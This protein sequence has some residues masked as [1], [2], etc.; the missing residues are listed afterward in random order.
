MNLHFS[1][2]VHLLILLAV[3]AVAGALVM[4]LRRRSEWGRSVRLALGLILAASELAWYGY[5]L[6]AGAFR[7]PDGLPLQLCDLTLW[8]AVAAALTLRPGI[9]EIAYYW[10]LGGDSMALLTPD[11]WAPFPSYPT[12]YFFVSHGLVVITVLTLT[13]GRLI[14]P[15]PGSMW[16]AFL[17]LNLYA[18][19]VGIFDAI[20]KTNYMYLLEKPAR[21]SLLDYFGPWP[22][23]ILVADAFALA[24]FW[25]FWLPFRSGGTR[26]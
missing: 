4:L 13:G 14:Q 18:A 12:V 21:A 5:V 9:Y 2:T 11:I 19:G 6:R 3:L 1:P 10:G 24:L 15:R 22:L 17:A 8:L 26:A 20:F 23:Y 25:L 7:F 16:R